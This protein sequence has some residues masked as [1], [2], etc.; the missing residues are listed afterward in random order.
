[1]TRIAHD[2][3]S[4]AS[5]VDGMHGLSVQEG[6]GLYGGESSSSGVLGFSGAGAD[7]CSGI[8]TVAEKTDA[9]QSGLINGRVCMLL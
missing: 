4:S 9:I 6:V 2:C 3:F 1:M 7:F 5:M 8:S